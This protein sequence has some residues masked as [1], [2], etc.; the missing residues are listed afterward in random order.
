[1]EPTYSLQSHIFNH[2]STAVYRD[3]NVYNPLNITHPP[4]STF[5][6]P[7]YSSPTADNDT[8]SIDMIIPQDCGGFSLGS[9]FTRRSLWTDRILDI[10]WD[11]V[12]YEQK[13]MQWEHKEQDALEHLYKTQPWVR[14]RVAFI[15][16]RKINSYPSGACRDEKK[17]AALQA[18]KQ[19][20]PDVAEEPVV[21]SV[22]GDYLG[23]EDEEF[24]NPRVHYRATDRDFTINLAGCF[25]GRDCWAE[26]YHYRELSKKLNQGSV[27]K[28]KS[29]WR[30]GDTG[31]GDEVGEYGQ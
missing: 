19:M 6:D 13:H 11:P 3:I 18:E 25:Y 14:T 30:K 2:L 1:M 10:W 9:F 22:E 29:W 12:L 31:P 21:D 5:L 23:N 24:L 16:Q 26:M 8:S 28:W 7:L 20:A 17:I 4:R 27:G 15:E